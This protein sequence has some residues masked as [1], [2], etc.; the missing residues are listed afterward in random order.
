MR[1][2]VCKPMASSATPI[3]TKAHAKAAWSLIS[4][5]KNAAQ[6][7]AADLATIKGKIL[8]ACHHFDVE[9]SE[10]ALPREGLVRALSGLEIRDMAERMA[11]RAR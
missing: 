10:N 7:S 8:T 6:Y 1:I 11:V 3:D 2:R 4:M 9:V 5:A